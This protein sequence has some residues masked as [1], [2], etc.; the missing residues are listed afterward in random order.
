MALQ[1]KDLPDGL[2]PYVREWAEALRGVAR[3]TGAPTSAA[4]AERLHIA[5]PTLSRY[6]AGERVEGALQTLPA[7]LGL[8]PEQRRRWS[9]VELDLLGRRTLALQ[10]APIPPPRATPDHTPDLPPTPA[11]PPPDL[12]APS[13]PGE[14]AGQAAV[15]VLEAGPEPSGSGRHW[16]AVLVVG[17]AVIVLAAGVGGALLAWGGNERPTSVAYAANRAA[18]AEFYRSS[19]RFVVADDHGDSLSAIVQYSIA[20]TPYPDVYNGQGRGTRKTFDLPLPPS[21]DLVGAVVFRVCVGS[22]KDRVPA[23][24]CGA[25]TT[26]RP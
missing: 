22:K 15:A 21:G 13:G 19:K 23:R 16:R 20:G 12:A 25:W 4:L 10:P 24:E 14:P 2:D 6:L 9:L 8:V 7:L 18:H 3:A 17:I 11:A 1:L 5:A 26:D